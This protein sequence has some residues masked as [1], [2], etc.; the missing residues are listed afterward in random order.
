MSSTDMNKELVLAHPPPAGP[1]VM[2]NLYK[3]KEGVQ[4]A[5]FLKE[6]ALVADDAFRG[7]SGRILYRGKV[8]AEFTNNESE[9]D[10][11]IPIEYD[12]WT[13]ITHFFEDNEM[14][15]KLNGIRRK[16]LADSRWT[17][18]THMGN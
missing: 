14:I 6:M 16:Y 12:D 10:Y 3:L 17:F 13:R 4:F 8:G 1:F 5:E 9:W 18:T 7:T 15:N 2:V 11:I